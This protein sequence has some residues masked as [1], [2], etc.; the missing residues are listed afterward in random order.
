M[1]K[2]YVGKTKDIYKNSVGN[3]VLK[4]KDDVTGA[5]GVF[6][7]G[8]NSVGLSIDGVGHEGLQITKYF[9]E[10]LKKRGVATHY[11]DCDLN[12]NTMTVKPA[13]VFGDGLEFICRFKATGSFFR[14]YGKYVKE[15]ADLDTYV[16]VTLKDDERCDPLVTED[17][18][19]ELNILTREEY[20][21]A[22]TLTKEVSTIVRDVLN[23]RGLTLFDI[24][25]E[26]GRIDG[27]IVLIDEISGG[28]MRVYKDNKFIA[29]TDLYSFLHD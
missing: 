14:R 22:V 25:L 28:N 10:I 17:A 23:D 6:D 1:K 16:E 13:Q 7:P 20:E 21:E 8:A 27:R 19:V 2:I 15:N 9:F 12:E 29:P 4:F 18:L 5:N 11:I 26:F 3:Y 24:K